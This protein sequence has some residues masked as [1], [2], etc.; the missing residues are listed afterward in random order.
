MCV[1]YN[2]SMRW[3]ISWISAGEYFFSIQFFYMYVSNKW[4]FNA[5]TKCTM[6]V[7]R[8]DI[9]FIWKCSC[10]RNFFFS[11]IFHSYISLLFPNV[12]VFFFCYRARF[13]LFWSMEFSIFYSKYHRK[14]SRKA[15]HCPYLLFLSEKKIISK[16]APERKM[17]KN[18]RQ[19]FG[20]LNHL[21]ESDFYKYIDV[22]IRED[23]GVKAEFVR[24][25]LML[26][27][28]QFRD[29][30]NIRAQKFSFR[31]EI[32]CFVIRYGL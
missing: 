4:V 16:G 25:L 31:S 12:V 20:M 9:R 32:R 2:V 13:T 23:L 3:K 26:Y 29:Y 27:I 10:F 6:E 22:Y 17:P 11:R 30:I 8:C 15:T 5:I 14:A 21:R 1:V 19:L 18:E 28:S 24:W 7:K